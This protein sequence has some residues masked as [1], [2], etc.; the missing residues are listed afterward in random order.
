MIVNTIL[1]HQVFGGFFIFTYFEIGISVLIP[2][3]L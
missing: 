1:S 3:L 2:I